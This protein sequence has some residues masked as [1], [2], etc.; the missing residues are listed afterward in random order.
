MCL[1]IVL[2]EPVRTA[3]QDRVTTVEV[4]GDT[5]WVDNGQVVSSNVRTGK[6][7]RVQAANRLE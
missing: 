4:E 6:R 7:A 3:A 1:A 5:S 2:D